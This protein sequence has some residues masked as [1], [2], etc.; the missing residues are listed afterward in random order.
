[1]PRPIGKK[2]KEIQQYMNVRTLE[3]LEMTGS[4]TTQTHVIDN[5]FYDLDPTKL[6]AMIHALLRNGY[7]NVQSHR[8]PDPKSKLVSVIAEYV[9]TPNEFNLNAM[10]DLGIELADAFGCTYDGWGTGTVRD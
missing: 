8:D 2:A 6:R 9:A 7:T 5:Y 4:D 1:M 10:T 3:L